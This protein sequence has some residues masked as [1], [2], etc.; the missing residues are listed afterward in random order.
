MRLPWLLLIQ[1]GPTWSA[2]TNRL[3]TTLVSAD[4]P[5]IHHP[6]QRGPTAA[7][8][9]VVYGP[10]SFLSFLFLLFSIFFLFAVFLFLYFEHY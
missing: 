3:Y 9:G 6:G 1:R 10:P 8:P 2:R 7:H 5:P 4:Q